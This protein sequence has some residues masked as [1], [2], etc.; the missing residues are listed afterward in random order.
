M[1]VEAGTISLHMYSTQDT[2]LNPDFTLVA[3]RRT[4]YV[5]PAI[6]YY[7]TAVPATVTIISRC[8]I[9]F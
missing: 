7:L 3:P 1:F 4:K 6:S 5:I 9:Y 8:G 2:G